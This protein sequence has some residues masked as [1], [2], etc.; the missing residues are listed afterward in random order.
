MLKIFEIYNTK[1]DNEK[2]DDWRLAGL[3]RT[4]L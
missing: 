2:S 1:A 4:I 3:W